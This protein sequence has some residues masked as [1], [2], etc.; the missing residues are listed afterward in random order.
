MRERGEK[1]WYAAYLKTRHWHELRRQVFE[2]DGHKCTRCPNRTRLEVHHLTYERLG[3]ELLSDL[4]TLCYDCHRA[5]HKEGN[6]GY[7]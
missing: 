6:T 1:G 5:I 7:D 4:T 2:R 3:D